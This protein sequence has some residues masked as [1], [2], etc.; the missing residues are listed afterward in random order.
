VARA[1]VQLVATVMAVTN[2]A[3]WVVWSRWERPGHG[4]ELRTRLRPPPLIGRGSDLV[5][6][7][8]LVY[9]VPVV[10]APGWAY[11]GWLNWSTRIDLVLQAVGLGLWALGIALGLRAARAMGGYGA[12]SG[13]T[14]DHQLV[15][16]GPYRHVRH[17]IYTAI[18]AIAVGTSLVF[19]SYLLL[20]VAALSTVTHR[21]WAAAEEE[22]LGSPEGLGDTYR[23]YASRTGRFLPRVRRVRR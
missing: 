11:E 13:V 20:V 3:A 7:A 5:Q 9:P 15:S 21:W 8:P 4:V 2:A 17:P 14:T 10:V 19:R 22:L 1:S 6:V 16:D 18:I 23:T 12:V